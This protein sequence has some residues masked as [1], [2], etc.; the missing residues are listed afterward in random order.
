MVLVVSYFVSTKQLE[1][2]QNKGEDSLL[3]IKCMNMHSSIYM[4]SAKEIQTVI[5]S[6]C[7]PWHCPMKYNMD[8]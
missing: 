6:E 4:A 7:P 8:F 3:K 1:S 2:P 5:G